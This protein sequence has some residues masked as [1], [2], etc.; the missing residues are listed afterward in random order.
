MSEMTSE[1]LEEIRAGSG[2]QFLEVCTYRFRG[3]SMGDPERYRTRRRSGNCQEKGPIENFQKYL[4]SKEIA[5][6]K[7]LK[8][9]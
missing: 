5:A 9:L 2:P 6:E 1:R 8:K 3:H 4:L 7:E